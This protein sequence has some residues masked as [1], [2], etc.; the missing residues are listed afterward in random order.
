MNIGFMLLGITGI[1]YGILLIRIGFGKWRRRIRCKVPVE[2]VF[3]RTVTK[4][5][6]DHVRT[7]A[8]FS[9]VERLSRR[10]KSSLEK[11][12]TYVI[13]INE[14]NPKKLC[15][16]RKN[17][18]MEDLFTF[19]LGVAFLLSGLFYLLQGMFFLNQLPKTYF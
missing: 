8:V 2:A 10:E 19:F 5:T 12:K 1:A 16:L 6:G 13:R 14:E 9:Y 17:F 7:Y 15:Y 3:E 4:K 11:G 18:Q